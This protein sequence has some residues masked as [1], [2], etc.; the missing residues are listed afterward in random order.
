MVS[1]P[2]ET[3]LGRYRILNQ[4]GAGG[5]ATVFK[6]H[7]PALGRDVA[8]KVLSSAYT[9][10][11][12]FL[13]RFS[14]EA[15]TVA[16]LSHPSISRIHDFGQDKGFTYIVMEYIT[17]GTLQ[18][19]LRGDPIS[20]EETVEVVRHLGDALDYAHAQGI[21]HRDIKPSNVLLDAD[22]NPILA[23]FGLAGMLEGAAR[24]T[25]SHV[26]VGT[27]AYMSPEQALGGVMDHRSDLYSLGIIVYEMLVGRTPFHGETPA[28]TLLAQV[29]R[30]PPAPRETNP[31]I[32]PKLEAVVLNTL[33]KDPEDRPESAVEMVRSLARAGGLN[34]DVIGQFEAVG[35][36]GEKDIKT[37]GEL[38][39]PAPGADQDTGVSRTPFARTWL[40]STVAAVAVV[41]A[42]LASALLV[43]RGGDGVRET[44]EAPSAG[45][46]IEK[47]MAAMAAMTQPGTGG[48]ELAALAH[49]H[50]GLT[51]PDERR[52]RPASLSRMRW[53]R[54]GPWTEFTEP[55]DVATTRAQQNVVELRDLSSRDAIKVQNNS[56]EQMAAIARRLSARDYLRADVFEEEELYKA[57][58]I[59][60]EET[61][62]E[63]YV[64]EVLSPESYALFDDESE[65]LHVR[66]GLSAIGP[67]DELAYA[68]SYLAAIQQQSFDVADL[69]R[70]A[71]AA[72]SDRFRAAVGLINGDLFQI[73]QSYHTMLRKENIVDD[74]GGPLSE[75][76]LR[77][78]PGPVQK[79]AYFAQ[80]HGSKFVSQL[81]ESTGSWRPVDEAYARPPVSTEQVLHPDKYFAGEKPVELELADFSAMLR[82]GWVQISVDT[83]GEFLLRTYLEEHLDATE[84]SSAA[85]GWGGDR[86]SLL[87][88]PAGERVLIWLVAW[89]S[90][91][92]SAEFF[93]SYQVFAAGKNR[94]PDT[95]ITLGE[96][97]WKSVTPEEKPYSRVRRR[98]AGVKMEP[99]GNSGGRWRRLTA[100]E[101]S[102]PEITPI[103]TTPAIPFRNRRRE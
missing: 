19:R 39:R 43:Y 15:Q 30:A 58:G 22:S 23:D 64:R 57:L 85:A 4:L 82:E 93:D 28:A 2:P 27:P 61:D 29:H 9:E 71:R 14:R 50:L 67:E 41:L 51:T 76:R 59:I 65:T 72:D 31:Q 33:A 36:Q 83:A 11:P 24:L 77:A 73:R 46:G 84:P 55:V 98:F 26:T 86:Y 6:A 70:Q 95:G 92:E 44:P 1:I 63:I 101:M 94:G 96:T 32:D 74:T 12:T 13:A 89:G 38:P 34:S 17:G 99:A 75:N 102:F 53:G 100:L 48:A 42:V 35:T 18:N 52:Y 54:C 40:I 62:L 56:G 68:S 90:L 20:L 91:E 7:D 47:A 60:A 5:M 45:I 97:I 66:G 16:R 3:S 80:V 69:R 78:A 79:T 103:A 87:R 37:Q 21:I 25:H 88:G 8:I 10:D 81:F 49:S